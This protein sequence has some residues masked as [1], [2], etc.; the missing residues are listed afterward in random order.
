MS[1]AKKK[2]NPF[3]MKRLAFTL[4]RYITHESFREVGRVFWRPWTP[5][6]GQPESHG[7]FTPFKKSCDL[8]N[9]AVHQRDLQ[10]CVV[11]RT[12]HLDT[13]FPHSSKTSNER[14]IK[15]KAEITFERR[16]HFPFAVV[17]PTLSG[18]Q[19][20]TTGFNQQAPKGF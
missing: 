4:R 12:V 13:F 6:P 10:F 18:W 3:H 7:L 15:R 9:S 20:V 5:S 8:R 17:S 2:I 1:M 11:K 19:I 16:E 14:K